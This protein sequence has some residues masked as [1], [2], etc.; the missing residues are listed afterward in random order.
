MPVTY[1]RLSDG[2]LQEFFGDDPDY[3]AQKV[4]EKELEIQHNNRI[5]AQRKFVT[6]PEYQP[7]EE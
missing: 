5:D 4:K 1:K 7:G 3:I 2:S 6:S